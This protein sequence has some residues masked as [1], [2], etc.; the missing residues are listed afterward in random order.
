MDFD[1]VTYVD[2][3][4]AVILW[5]VGAYI[6]NSKALQK[7]SNDLIPIVLVILGVAL[8]LFLNGVTKGSFVAGIITAIFCVG[9]HGSIK[10]TIVHFKSDEK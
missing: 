7:F 3:V 8:N 1:I 9:S 4:I 6:K 5:A 10:N 2:P